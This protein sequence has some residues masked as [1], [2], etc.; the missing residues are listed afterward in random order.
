LPPLW[1]PPCCL[2]YVPFPSHWRSQSLQRSATAFSCRQI[3][4]LFEWISHS[5][6]YETVLMGRIFEI[7][8]LNLVLTANKAH[9]YRNNERQ[10]KADAEEASSLRCGRCA[11]AGKHS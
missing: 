11:A 6:S 7:K 5:V 3:T 2:P 1:A 9:V 10:T 8:V 4:W